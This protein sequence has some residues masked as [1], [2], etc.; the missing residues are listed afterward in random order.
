MI[1]DP[2]C[3]EHQCEVCGDW[4]IA[5][6]RCRLRADRVGRTDRL[7]L[8]LEVDRATWR[9]VGGA[10]TRDDAEARAHNLRRLADEARA[11]ADEAVS[12]WEA[13]Q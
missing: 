1:E 3:I 8:D 5:D 12:V 6:H 7:V 13:G 9:I 11:A 2:E 10:F 4:F